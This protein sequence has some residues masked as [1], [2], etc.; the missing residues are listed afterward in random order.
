MAQNHISCGDVMD[1]QNGGTAL[2]VGVGVKIGLRI[3]VTLVAIAANATGAVQ[4][5]GVFKV[6]KAASQ[7]WTQGALVYW[8][9]T[10]K[11]FTTTA[12]GNTLAGFAWE[13]V[14]NGAGETTGYVKLNA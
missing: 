13:P 1:Y 10:N 5:E 7:A 4:L 2:A 8:D 9:D 11:V 14:G 12:S 3:G 6:A